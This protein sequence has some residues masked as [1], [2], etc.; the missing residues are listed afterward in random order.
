MFNGHF[1]NMRTRPGNVSSRKVTPTEPCESFM[2]KAQALESNSIQTSALPQTS[3]NM[4]FLKF[5]RLATLIKMGL[6]KKKNL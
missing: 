1:I 5:S 4:G 6:E 2:G 3:N